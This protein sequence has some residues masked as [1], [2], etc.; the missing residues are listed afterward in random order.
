[1]KEIDIK[2]VI[3][4]A[5]DESGMKRREIAEQLRISQQA[6]S[7]VLTK[8]DR[9]VSTT[10]II[11]LINVLNNPDYERIAVTYI[12]NL[13]LLYQKR[14]VLKHATLDRVYVQREEL[15]A[16]QKFDA[17]AEILNKAP[18]TCND[19]ELDQ[20]RSLKKEWGEQ[21][22]AEMSVYCDLIDYINTA[23]N[24]YVYEEV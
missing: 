11:K 24:H 21:I 4:K 18:E 12:S 19:S 15:E 2:D 6:L 10:M 22:G 7:N 14:S 16:N 20:I 23:Q 3:I 5:I 1:M 8:P 9:R 13:N 17:V